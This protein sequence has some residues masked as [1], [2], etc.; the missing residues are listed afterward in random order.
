MKASTRQLIVNG[1]TFYVKRD[2]DGTMWLES[3][4]WAEDSEPWQKII[5]LLKSAQTEGDLEF[6]DAMENS[7]IMSIGWTKPSW[8]IK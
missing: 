8:T 1:Y 7:R 3:D 6:Q 5:T 2:K 4:G